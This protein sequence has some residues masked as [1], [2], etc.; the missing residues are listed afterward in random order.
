MPSGSFGHFPRRQNGKQAEDANEDEDDLLE[1]DQ[2]TTR[3]TVLWLIDAGPKMHDQMVPLKEKREGEEEMDEDQSSVV[4]VSLF[5]KAMQAAYM[6]QRSKLVNSPADTCG[7]LLFNTEKTDVQEAGK[8]V[9]YPNSIT[10]QSI[11]QVAVPPVSDLKDD[12]Q[13]ECYAYYRD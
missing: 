13:S 4:K 12:L 3:D 9:A 7:I 1:W 6:F 11:S 2:P 8:N 5:H 10:I